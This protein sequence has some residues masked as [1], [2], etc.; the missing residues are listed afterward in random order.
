MTRNN[1]RR[2]AGTI[3]AGSMADIAFLLLIFF[4]VTAT[5]LDYRGILVKLP[6]WQDPATVPPM[7]VNSRNVLSVKL[8]GSN[9]LL[10]KGERMELASLRE[11]TKL[12]IINP[13]NSPRKAIVSLQHDRGTDYE[14]YLLVY[15]E[16]KGAYNE[17]WEER[18]QQEYGLAFSQL[19]KA[20]RRLVRGEIPL[21]IS[22]AEPTAHLE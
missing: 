2:R 22:E 14:H 8:N 9:E 5:I 20:K 12:F 6:I 19:S 15:N 21:V 18:S 16:L 7:D 11:A 4:L 17:L 13:D 10:V 3:S 1:K